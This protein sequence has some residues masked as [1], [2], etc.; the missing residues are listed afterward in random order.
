LLG[1]REHLLKLTQISVLSNL[2]HTSAGLEHKDTVKTSVVD[3]VYK[4]NNTN[5][6]TAGP[7]ILW[8]PAQFVSNSIINPLTNNDCRTGHEAFSFMTSLLAKSM[9]EV[10]GG[11][12]SLPR[13]QK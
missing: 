7:I 11:C 9:G 5:V 10:G 4:H 6:F 13:G 12:M 3:D 2:H 1:R 8:V